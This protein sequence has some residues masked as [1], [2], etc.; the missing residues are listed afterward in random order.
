MRVSDEVA[1]VTGPSRRIGEAIARTFAR[2][3]ASLL[4][5]RRSADRRPL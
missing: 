4:V 3:A 5:P 2:E 1:L